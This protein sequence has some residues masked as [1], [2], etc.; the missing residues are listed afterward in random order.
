MSAPMTIEQ[1]LSMLER[2]W[3]R[4]DPIAPCLSTGSFSTITYKDFRCLNLTCND[5]VH[6]SVRH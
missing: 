1:F 3:G 5:V 4:V 2:G 6:D